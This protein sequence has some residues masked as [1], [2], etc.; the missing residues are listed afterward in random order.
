[1][2]WL[3][4]QGLAVE[5][6]DARGWENQGGVADGHWSRHQ[7]WRS[8]YCILM[9]EGKLSS[10]QRHLA[11]TWTNQVKRLMLAP[12]ASTVIVYSSRT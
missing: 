7:V 5:R 3:A 10:S 1:M 6:V 8:W 4:G 9:P 12:D 2:V 11:I